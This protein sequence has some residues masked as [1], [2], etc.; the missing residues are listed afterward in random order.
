MKNYVNEMFLEMVEKWGKN[1]L[2]E[3]FDTKICRFRK[4]QDSIGQL[5]AMSW[6]MYSLLLELFSFVFT[7]S[8]KCIRKRKPVWLNIETWVV[9]NLRPDNAKM[10]ICYRSLPLRKFWDGQRRKLHSCII[11]WSW[12]VRRSGHTRIYL[13][14]TEI[15]CLCN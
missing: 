11:S 14:V 3:K 7:V 9:Q 2:N 5:E 4:A 13:N 15:L 6:P 12:F 10:E 8:V 1:K